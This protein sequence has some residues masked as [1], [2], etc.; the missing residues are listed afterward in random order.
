[1][2]A[3]SRNSAGNLQGS[4]R[5]TGGVCA[6]PNPPV[7]NANGVVSSASC[8]GL[9]PVAPGSLI[10][11]L[12]AHLAA[13]PL[14]AETLPLPIELGQ[15]QALIGARELP[16]IFVSDGQINAV[17][18]YDVAVNT[19]QQ[20]VV[21]RGT[22]YTTPVDVTLTPVEPGVFTRDLS[23]TGQGFVFD[24]GFHFVDA[25]NPA[26]AGD[27]LAI[28]ITG[29]GEVT[30]PIAAG[31]VAPVDSLHLTVNPVAVSIGGVNA[32]QVLFAG[33]APGYTGLYQVKV[34]VPE[35]VA[36]GAG[37]PVIV[38]AADRPGPAVTIAVR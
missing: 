15:T 28:Y 2:T 20:I 21:R 3:Q 1:M 5:V 10:A 8:A 33:L 6:N 4:A 7:I 29:L 23:G 9:A 17:L 18:P 13:A 37:V 12:G 26:R 27:I 36:P 30:P 32:P 22:S 19:R 38:S 11:I 34:V 35:G 16:L 24:A 25:A 31:S 14:S